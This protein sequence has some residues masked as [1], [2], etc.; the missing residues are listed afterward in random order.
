MKTL[1]YITAV[2][3]IV[4]SFSD[5]L[6]ARNFK[7]VWRDD[8]RGRALDD[9]KWSRIPRGQSDWRNYMS[10]HE[11]LC[12]LK[13]GKLVIKAVANDGVEPSDTAKFL[14]GGVYTKDKFRICEGKVEIRARFESGTSVWPALWMLP[15][16]GKWP[17]AGE[18][19]I[20]EHLNHDRF[21]YQTVHTGYT[22][23]SEN[24]YNPVSHVK[25][26]ID[27]SEYNVY[28]VEIHQD[29]V[30]FLLNGK[31]TLR[32]PRLESG[33]H[34]GNTQFPFGT[35]YYIL[36]DTQIGGSWVGDAVGTDLPVSMYIDWI[37]VYERL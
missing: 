3:L 4:A 14:T 19:D 16:E 30:I 24:R 5:T 18:I 29:C 11:D 17:D 36:M 25:V 27:P 8:F 20:M 35:P 12:E 1:N 26:N 13:R 31:E 28:G 23:V 15:Q 37:K 34:S 6:Q 7:L 2:L 32:Y 10:F 21:V 33:E 22:M 9:E